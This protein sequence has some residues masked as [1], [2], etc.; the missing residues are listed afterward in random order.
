MVSDSRPDSAGRS[1]ADIYDE[2]FVPALF[3]QWGPV[4]CDAAQV[5]RG[6]QVLDVACGT[7]ALTLALADRVGPEG[8]VH[9]LDASPQMLAVAGRKVARIAW[10]HGR[11]EALPFGDAAFDAVLSQFGLMFFEG[12]VAGL[13]EMQRVLRPGGRLAVA[14][15]DALARSAGYAALD[16]LLER[17]FGPSVA[18]AFRAPFALGDEQRLLALCA[19]AG[20]RDAQVVRREGTVRFASVEA[21]VST[22][23]ACVWTLGG[24][25]DDGQ[26]E[27]LLREARLE[28]APFVN[29]GGQVAFTMPALLIC[30]SK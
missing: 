9:G 1:P 19:Q 28:F 2:Q 10:V 8:A 30:A 12:R 16:A 5:R 20:I 15:C 24:L 11:A 6:Q 25:L 26:F 23:R 17:L 3:R 22:E 27:Q 14:V 7:G 21:L 13:R 4:L 29:A 18:G